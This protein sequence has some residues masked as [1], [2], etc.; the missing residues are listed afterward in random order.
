MASKLFSLFMVH[1][2]IESY[3]FYSKFSHL[4]V[5]PPPIYMPIFWGAR[6][7]TN[8]IPIHLRNPKTMG[9]ILNLA[10]SRLPLFEPPNPWGA[11]S[12]KLCSSILTIAKTMSLMPSRFQNLQNLGNSKYLFFQVFPACFFTWRNRKMPFILLRHV[13]ETSGVCCSY[14]CC[15]LPKL[16]V[17][18]LLTIEK[19][20]MTFSKIERWLKA[21]VCIFNAHIKT[22][23]H[24]SLDFHIPWPWF[25][26]YVDGLERWTGTYL[27]TYICLYLKIND[28]N[29][30]KFFSF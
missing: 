21:N 15:Y 25:F 20:V 16:R 23:F 19:R 1:G 29:Y 24:W 11:S 12:P 6:G 9:L 17:H 3:G 28:Y 22:N 14:E 7:G 2:D 18:D 8:G 13:T 27:H 4:T 10:I 26:M 5:S 30:I